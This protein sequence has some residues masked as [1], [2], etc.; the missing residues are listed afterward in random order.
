MIFS[1]LQP[2]ASQSQAASKTRAHLHHKHTKAL[3]EFSNKFLKPDIVLVLR[4]IASNV[5]GLVVSE[6]VKYLWESFL[7]SR[8][9]DLDPDDLIQDYDNG[10][11]SYDDDEQDERTAA[12][13]IS[14][15]PVEPNNSNKQTNPIKRVLG[16]RASSN[17]DDGANKNPDV[18]RIKGADKPSTSA[19]LS[20]V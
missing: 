7:Q 14:R 6:L 20:E 15:Q 9:K 1:S 8:G 2:Q 4:I 16:F 13:P 18:N 19:P 3:N 10:D 17:S 5:N 11:A 12:F